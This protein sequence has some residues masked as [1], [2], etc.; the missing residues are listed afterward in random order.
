MAFRDNIHYKEF[1]C[2]LPF[3]CVGTLLEI[4]A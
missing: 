2:M 3:A 4:Y 1:G